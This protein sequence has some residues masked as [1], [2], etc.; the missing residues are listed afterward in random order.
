MKKVRLNKKFVPKA[1][2]LWIFSNE[3]EDR[4]SK[5]EAGELVEVYLANGKFY[6]IGYINPKSLIAIRIL[7]FVQRDIDKDF[8]IERIETAYKH[9]EL[10]NYTGFDAYRLCYSESDFL[11][12]LIIDKYN[13]FFVVQTLTAGMDKI[14]PVVKEILIEKFKP[15]GIILKNDSNFRTLEGIE[16]NV[17]VDYGK[18][19][20]TIV[21][22]EKGV[23]YTLNLLS[24]QKTG[25]FLDQ[26]ENRIYLR[27]LLK[28]RIINKILDC[29][30]YSG[31]W[32]FSAG[33]SSDGEIICVDSSEGAIQLIKKNSEINRRRVTV[34][35]EDVFD[36][37]KKSHTRGEKFDC[38]ILDPPAFIKSRSKIKE[39]LKG[40]KEIN[41]RAMRLLSKGGLLV[42]ASCS[43]HMERE[44]FIQMLKDCAND[45]KRSFRVVHRGYQ[46]PDHPILLN[47]PETDYLK[48]V[49]LENID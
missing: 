27:N 29:F 33:I 24:G 12:G 34:F 14:Y 20:D 46:A 43:H 36:F 32:A 15:E 30:S 13:K 8:F 2:Y 6:C 7:S 31:G 35:K 10:I 1:F 28:N 18:Y 39:G 44:Q 23:K 41:Q 45:S 9:R 3:I 26:R 49:F 4:L 38:I 5:Y 22:D 19:E 17:S 40:Y 25:F 47:M 42:T 16:K 48:V 37:L 11:P 21:I